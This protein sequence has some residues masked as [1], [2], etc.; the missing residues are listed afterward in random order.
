[1]IITP[2]ASS[3]WSIGIF[4][5][6]HQ[7]TRSRCWLPSLRWSLWMWRNVVQRH[8]Q[9]SLKPVLKM[10]MRCWVAL[11]LMTTTIRICHGDRYRMDMCM[12]RVNWREK[13][14]SAVVQR[15]VRSHSMVNTRYCLPWT[16]IGLWH[17]LIRVRHCMWMALWN[18]VWWPVLPRVSLFVR[19][20]R[21]I[22]RHGSATL[23]RLTGRAKVTQ[24]S[25][26]M[27][28]E[29]TREKRSGRM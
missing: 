2:W 11:I 9:S 13:L 10:N 12:Q 20:K 1:M 8:K 26:L 3:R 15:K 18:Q 25:A 6:Q 24:S 28:R 19:V 29:R 7:Q 14:I 4:W 23:H 22:A 17:R 27:C 5:Q 21:C 16:K